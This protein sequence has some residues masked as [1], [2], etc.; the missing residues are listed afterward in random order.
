[1]VFL[2]A[3]FSEEYVRYLYSA[4]C[5]PNPLYLMIHRSA[6]YD[7]A[8]SDERRAAAEVIVALALLFIEQEQVLD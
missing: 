7:L 3:T 4:T 1:M 8:N 6:E 2:E 5:P